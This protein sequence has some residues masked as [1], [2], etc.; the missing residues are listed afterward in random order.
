MREP[1]VVFVV[2]TLS[3]YAACFGAQVTLSSSST[4]SITNFYQDFSY[5]SCDITPSL[6]DNYCCCDSSC[7]ASTVSSWKGS[8]KCLE[9]GS[10]V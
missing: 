2:L 10:D 8:Y 9:S 7:S 1:L 6:C 5:C 4:A 3:W